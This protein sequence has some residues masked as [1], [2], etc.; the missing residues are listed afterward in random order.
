[1]L[2]K[3]LLNVQVDTYIVYYIYIAKITQLHL[4]KSNISN[5]FSNDLQKVKKTKFWTS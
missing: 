4:P 5:Y 2:N 3:A 1:M